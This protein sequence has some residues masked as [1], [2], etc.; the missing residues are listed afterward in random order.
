MHYRLHDKILNG[1]FT[2]T[3]GLGKGKINIEHYTFIWNRGFPK[4]WMLDM[5]PL[6]VPTNAIISISPGQQ[7][8]IEHAAHDY[9]VLQYNKAFYCVEVHDEEVSCNGMLFN[10]ALLAPVLILDE[11]EQRSFGILLDVIQEE[12]QENDDVQLEM[13][14]T[15]LKRFIIKCTRLAKNQFAARLSDNKDIDTFRLFNALVEKHFRKYHL[16][17]DY[18]LLLNKSPKTLSNLFKTLHYNSPLH[19][20]HERIILEA[21]KLL[22]YTDKSA[23]EI[24]YELGLSDPVQFSRL[25]KKVTGL[26]PVEFKRKG[27]TLAQN[28]N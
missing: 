27:L 6:H 8:E 26:S 2:L 10:G 17:S 13:L 7:I 3:N 11:K 15:M 1:Q 21:K 20:I 16:V 5:L 18:A 22:I 24:S 9:L 25:F 12:F 4:R 23:K 28:S 14:K 19:V